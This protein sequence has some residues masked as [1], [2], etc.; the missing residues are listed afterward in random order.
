M[1]WMWDVVTKR[2]VDA[3]YVVSQAVPERGLR[4]AGSSATHL[5]SHSIAEVSVGDLGTLVL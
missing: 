1:R 4:A 3:G 5:L 2:S